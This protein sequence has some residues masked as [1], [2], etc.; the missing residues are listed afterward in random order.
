MQDRTSSGGLAPGIAVVAGA[1]AAIGSF[2]AWAKASVPQGGLSVSAKGIDG[3]EGKATILGGA[4]LLVGGISALAGQAGARQRLRLSALI[5][6]AIVAGVGVYT[7]TTAKDQVIDGAASEI[8]KELSISVEQAKAAVHTAIDQG[9]LKI[10]LDLGLFLVIGAGIIGI[11]AGVLAM[12]GGGD[13]ASSSMGMPAATATGAGMTN[14]AAATPRQPEMPPA[15]AAPAAESPW[16]TSPPPP[17][18][19]EP[20]AEPAPPEDPGQQ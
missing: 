4:I 5:G 9:A 19:A 20:S 14:W 8:A 13:V 2:L 17:A 16:A 1:L 10:G 11:V 12:M 6:G 15:P 18:P 7:A 3:W